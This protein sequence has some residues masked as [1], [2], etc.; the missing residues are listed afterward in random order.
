[1]ADASMINLD[2]AT[3]IAEKHDRPRGSKNKLK[4]S[5]TTSSTTTLA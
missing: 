1:M 4:T 2:D 3:I 5:A